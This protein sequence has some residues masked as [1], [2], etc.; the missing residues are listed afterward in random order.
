MATNHH[1]RF[2][3]CNGVDNLFAWEAQKSSNYWHEEADSQFIDSEERRYRNQSDEK[4][5]QDLNARLIQYK[6]E[7]ELTRMGVK[8]SK[9]GG[10]DQIYGF[11]ASV[12]ATKYRAVATALAKG[13]VPALTNCGV[14][15]VGFFV[16]A[17][18]FLTAQKLLLE[19]EP[20]LRKGLKP[21]EIE[22]VRLWGSQY[23]GSQNP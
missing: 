15:Q 3:F 7:A 18:Q 11:I 21:D 5:I 1:L 23:P 19:I 14:N 4:I 2:T 12:P 16:N 6:P 20:E 17:K 13:R 22:R 10:S 8:V 9:T